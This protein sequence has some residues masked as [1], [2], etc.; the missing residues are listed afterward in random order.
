MTNKLKEEINN[1]LKNAEIM[2]EAIIKLFNYIP[3]TSK[4]IGEFNLIQLTSKEATNRLNQS[5]V[6]EI[7]SFHLTSQQIHFMTKDL[8]DRCKKYMYSA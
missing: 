6:G 3:A 5:K 8:L 7:K 1:N 4:M 2:L